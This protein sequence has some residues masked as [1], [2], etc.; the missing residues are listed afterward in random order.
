MKAEECIKVQ[1]ELTLLEHGLYDD[2]IYK[3]IRN[4]EK[5]SNKYQCDFKDIVFSKTREG[6]LLDG[7][8]STTKMYSGKS[9]DIVVLRT[10]WF[11]N[12]K[13]PELFGD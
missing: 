10:W 11:K 4:D 3:S 7:V 12:Y 9:P 5:I 6:K 2:E 13:H 1:M 8:K